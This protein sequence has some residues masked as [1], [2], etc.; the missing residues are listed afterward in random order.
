[1]IG[2]TR[3]PESSN[4][5]VSVSH[6]IHYRCTVGW[7]HV[8]YIGKMHSQHKHAQTSP[9]HTQISFHLIY[10]D[11]SRDI[12]LSAF[13]VYSKFWAVAS[14]RPYTRAG[15]RKQSATMQSNVFPRMRRATFFKRQS[16]VK[17]VQLFRCATLLLE[18]SHVRWL[19]FRAG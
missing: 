8:M 13:A 14:I 19:L 9:G 4:E 15:R 12:L 17:T 16:P 10:N 2:L 11:R 3:S 1:M 7:F 18:A 5:P 6:S